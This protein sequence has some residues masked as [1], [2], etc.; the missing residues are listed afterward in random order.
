[1]II[2]KRND[3]GSYFGGS[4]VSRTETHDL[5]FAI[6]GD[7][8]C[9][10][11]FNFIVECKF[12]KTPPSFNAIVKDTV[13]QWDKWLEQ[14]EADSAKADKEPL[15]I[16]KYNRTEPFCFF[17]KEFLKKLDIEPIM[18]YSNKYS[19]ILLET[20]LTMEDSIFFSER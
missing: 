18:L 15:T 12:Y 11:H 17:R 2:V 3:S 4:N 9:P 1:M 14:N 5:D 16:I 10:R 6:Y 20:A 19:L 13:P 7:L 8:I